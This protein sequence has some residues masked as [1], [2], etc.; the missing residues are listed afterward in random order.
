VSTVWKCTAA[1]YEDQQVAE[2]SWRRRGFE[3]WKSLDR[4]RLLVWATLILGA[5][6]RLRHFFANRSVWIDEA[7][8]ALNLIDHDFS[9]LLGPLDYQQVCPVGFLFLAKLSIQALG[10]AEKPLRLISLVSGIAALFVFHRVAKRLLPAGVTLVVTALFALNPELIDHSAEVKPYSS[11]VLL[12]LL[13]LSAALSLYDSPSSKRRLILFIVTVTAAPW[14][15]YPALFTTAGALGALAFSAVRG[16]HW[17]HLSAIGAAALLWAGSM[18]AFWSLEVR[19]NALP[20][21]AWKD[22][23][24]PSLRFP[25][26]AF[27]WLTNKFV[28]V[29]ETPLGFGREA[30]G[31]AACAFVVGFIAAVREGRRQRHVLL[32]LFLPVVLT[33]FAA[34]LHRYPFWRRFILFLAPLLLLIVGLG[35]ARASTALRGALVPL[36]ALPLLFLSPTR[37]AV[38]R[39][40][41]PELREEIRPVMQALERNKTNDEGLYVFRYGEPAFRYYLSSSKE[42]PNLN[43]AAGGTSRTRVPSGMDPAGDYR[44]DL[45]TREVTA[46]CGAPVWILAS[47]VNTDE[48]QILL[49]RVDPLGVRRKTISAP[50]AV[51]HL[52]DLQCDRN[53]LPGR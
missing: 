6:L 19:P 20:P 2:G 53:R 38:Y 34:E 7:W 12:S 41:R 35:F 15:S 36:V 11:D 51:A 1:P 28:E 40:L 18:A 27:R 26:Q 3:V 30:A 31:V 42:F 9:H 25:V 16:R 43:R 49:D 10:A 8:V 29:F 48:E 45:L 33:L 46:L 50:G 5:V 17:R 24:M 44:W 21:N 37:T 39:L 47:H 22:A 13:V 4:S 23:F 52:Y 32:M 14:F